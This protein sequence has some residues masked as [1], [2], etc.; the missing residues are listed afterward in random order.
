MTQKIRETDLY[1]PVKM[2]FEAE[3]YE[4][5]SEIYGCDVV[6]IKDNNPVAIIELKTKFSLELVL[7]GVERLSVSGIIYLAI[8]EGPRSGLKKRLNKIIKLCR[9][10]GFGILLVTLPKNAVGYVTKILEPL[11][12]RPS[13]QKKSNRL[14]KEFKN[15][16]GDPNTGGSTAMPLMTAYKQNAL[17][18]VNG[19]ENGCKTIPELRKKTGVYNT[20][21]I[22]QRNFYGWFS[23]VDRGVYELSSAGIQS[24]REYAS[25]IHDLINPYK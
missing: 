17:R 1:K 20:A 23:R 16:H 15:R 11:P 21:S 19:L 7:Q 2:F 6:A 14:L 8:L 9:I 3:G 25:I 18:I 13:N 12:N 4:V 22:L 10:L 24:S 5:K